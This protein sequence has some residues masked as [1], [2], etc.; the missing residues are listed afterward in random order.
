MFLRNILRDGF[1]FLHI[2]QRRKLVRYA[3]C[4]RV[5]FPVVCGEAAIV[6]SGKKDPLLTIAASPL[7]FRRKQQGKNPSGT[8]G[9]G[10]SAE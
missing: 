8:Q 1:F 6:T 9:T 3:G 7:N 2:V 10:T 4:Q 5:F